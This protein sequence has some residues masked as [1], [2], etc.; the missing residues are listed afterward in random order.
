MSFCMI[1]LGTQSPHCEETHIAPRETQQDGST[2]LPAR[3]VSCSPCSFPSNC[4]SLFLMEQRTAFPMEHCLN[5]KPTWKINDHG[6]FQ[7]A[8]FW[9]GGLLYSNNKEYS[10][11]QPS[12]CKYYEKWKLLVNSRESNQLYFVLFQDKQ[13]AKPWFSQPSQQLAHV[14]ERGGG[15]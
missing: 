6:C 2:N 11:F 3:W 15:C 7:L 8:I 4:L 5:C 1:A 14:Q 10:Y 13:V 9:G 12:S